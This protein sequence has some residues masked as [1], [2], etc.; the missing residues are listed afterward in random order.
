MREVTGGEG[1]DPPWGVLTAGHSPDSGSQRGEG[2]GRGGG[3]GAVNGTAR[4]A[5]SSWAWGP[6]RSEALCV[7][8]DHLLV[9]VTS[10][11]C[12]GPKAS[13]VRSLCIRGPGLKKEGASGSPARLPGLQMGG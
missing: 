7:G 2:G 11:L 9:M 4:Q 12:P 1:R 10:I 3:G 5:R 8:S 13:G 6:Q